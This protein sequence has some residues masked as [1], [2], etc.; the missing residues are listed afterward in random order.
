M[1]II[2]SKLMLLITLIPVASFCM[3][4]Y[5]T[6][7]NMKVTERFRDFIKQEIVVKSLNDIG[8]S[9]TSTVAASIIMKTLYEAKDNAIRLIWGATQEDKMKSL[10]QRKMEQELKERN[11][12]FTIAE[13]QVKKKKYEE[14]KV[15]MKSL[16]QEAESPEE[17]EALQK[18]FKDTQDK[19]MATY[20][21]RLLHGFSNKPTASNSMQ[22]DNS[23]SALP[24]M[25]MPAA[26]AGQTQQ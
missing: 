18:R 10:Y 7:I 19:F 22:Q 11:A 26:S 9:V 5:A 14:Y 2:A 21:T 6:F 13:D 8:I 23:T 16:I 4:P 25:P 24:K 17:K 20:E 1:N 15:Y 12:T 3:N